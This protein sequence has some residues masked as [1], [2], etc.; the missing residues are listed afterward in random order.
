MPSSLRTIL[1]LL[2]LVAATTAL[3]WPTSRHGFVYDDG[4]YITNNEVVKQGLTA[5]GFKW[6]FT[7]DYA[8]NWHPLTWLSHMLDV[9]I[10]GFEN[11]AGHHWVSVG[12]HVLNAC[13][14]LLLWRRMT[15]DFWLAAFIA[16]AFALHPLH[17]ESVA[18]IAE[19]K[20]L[21]STLFGLLAIAAY[22]RFVRRRS[23]IAYVAMLLAF[24]MSLLAKPMLVTLPCLLL[25]LDFWPLRRIGVTAQSPDGVGKALVEQ[26]PGW[27]W[28]ALR[29]IVLE[30]LPLLALSGAA[31]GAAWIA[32]SAGGSMR[33]LEEM[34]LSARL[35]NAAVSYVQYLN[36][37]FWPL[38][39]AAFYPLRASWPGSSVAGAAA[40]LV[41]ATVVFI[42]VRRRQPWLIVGWLWFLGML[43]PVIGLV[44]VGSQSMADRYMYLPQVGVAIL[45]AYG[46]CAVIGRE[47]SPALWVASIMSL[48][49]MWM[50]SGIQIRT[51][52][53][54]EALWDHALKTTGGEKSENWKAHHNLGHALMEKGRRREAIEH[55][56]KALQ[57]G[58]VDVDM[59]FSLADAYLRD[60]QVKAAR[61]WFANILQ[62]QDQMHVER[63]H[64]GALSG[65]AWILATAD[66]PSLRNGEAAVRLAEQLCRQ[67]NYADPGNLD[68]LA[69]AY[70]EAGNFPAALLTADQALKIASKAGDRGLEA[71]INRHIEQFK[72]QRP[73]HP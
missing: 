35:A 55:F 57:T 19:R 11:A 12:L 20:D 26:G 31:S 48:A 16:F 5:A 59:M 68:T 53:D 56:T 10:F 45:V 40:V 6:A 64:E 42:L 9:R 67:T 3:Y 66:D 4:L 18:W 17:V 7:T 2:V 72:A 63:K 46:A 28:P 30:K 54:S 8:S 33:S 52:A 41:L 29:R 43:V 65:A 60:G 24:A 51:W 13:I 73:L 47:R 32:Q 38:D 71:D 70:A 37:T 39:L 27:N 44:Q 23:V 15:G 58:P 14:L 62:L 25:L 49:A 36:K 50:L 34:P 22:V 1:T 61:Q 21:L 69:A